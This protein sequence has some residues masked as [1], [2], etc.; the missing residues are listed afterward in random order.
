[1]IHGIGT[2]LVAIARLDAMHTRHGERLARRIL[3]ESEWPDYA[4]AAVPARLLAKRF[5]AK[6]ALAKALGT[7]LRAPVT[8][9]NIAIGHDALGRPAFTVAAP[10]AE[11]LDARGIVRLHLS[12]SDE[13]DHALAF[14]IAET[15]T[16]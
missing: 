10:L 13:R 14:A 16:C 9:G 7:G 4:A 3:A 8:L 1:M 2:D 15:E 11:W 5:A 12:L 6:E